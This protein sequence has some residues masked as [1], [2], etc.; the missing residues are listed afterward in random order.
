MNDDELMRDGWMLNPDGTLHG[1]EVVESAV[2]ASPDGPMIQFVYAFTA[3]E[4]AAG[5]LRMMQFQLDATDAEAFA[6]ALLE[7]A[8]RRPRLAS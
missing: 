1:A 8:R 5:R 7:S 6:L 4:K 2:L 3:G